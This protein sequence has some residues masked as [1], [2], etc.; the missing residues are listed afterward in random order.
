[1]GMPWNSYICGMIR[2]NF[3]WVV[4]FL[5]V[6]VISFK[7]VSSCSYDRGSEENNHNYEILTDSLKITRDKLGNEVAKREVLEFQSVKDIENLSNISEEV[8]TLKNSVRE[9][10]GKLRNATL[11]KNETNVS[12]SGTT[13]VIRDTVT[14]SPIYKTSW[15][16]KW[17]KGFIQARVD[18]ILYD[19]KVKNEFILSMGGEKKG[20]FGKRKTTATIKNLN[21]NTYTKEVITFDVTPKAK[22]FGMGIVGGIGFTNFKTSTPFVGIGVYYT[23]LS[24]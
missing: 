11:L 4:I 10:K 8:R 22:R 20:L 5:I 2:V 6:M 18:S 16:D 24:F 19:F 23:L 14:E 1:M 3:S 7:L 13:T 17:S 15:E 9:Y 21:P 12:G